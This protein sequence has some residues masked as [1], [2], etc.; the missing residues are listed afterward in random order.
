MDVAAF[1]CAPYKKRSLRNIIVKSIFSIQHLAFNMQ[2][3]EPTEQTTLK[4]YVPLI[5]LLLLI[6]VAS[7]ITC[8]SADSFLLNFMIGFFLVFGGFKLI[9]L[10]G[11]A[12]GYATY[13]LLAMRWRGYGYIYPFIEVAFGLSMLAGFHPDWLLWTEAGV[14]L[15]GGIGVAIKL[16]KR[17]AI[18]C[19]CLGTVLKVPLTTVSLVENFGMTAIAVYLVMG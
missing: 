7:G 5:V 12:A 13:D 9:D 18:S 3:T 19:V 10:E 11:F 15:F 2:H 6:T 17:E 1:L 16:M 4:S 14:M 8:D